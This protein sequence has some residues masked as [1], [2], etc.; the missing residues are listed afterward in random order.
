MLRSGNRDRLVGGIGRVSVAHDRL[1]GRELFLC[2]SDC[3]LEFLR[4]NDDNCV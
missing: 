4:R 3:L 2:N 1:F